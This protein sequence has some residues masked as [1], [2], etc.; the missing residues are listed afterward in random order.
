MKTMR[1]LAIALVSLVLPTMAIAQELNQYQPG[2]RLIDGS[3]LNLM[4]DTVNG[5][6]NNGAVTSNIVSGVAAGY[7]IARGETA[8]DGTNPTPV[9]T[10]L[11]TI[12]SCTLTVKIATSTGVDTSMLTYGTSSGT[13]NMYAWKPT[14]SSDTTLVA[15]TGTQTVG[16]ICVGT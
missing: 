7:K 10:S 16:W 15:S 6:T 3:Q 2:P 4:V 11:T 8:L 14:S 5:L 9:T 12:V 1:F 13:L